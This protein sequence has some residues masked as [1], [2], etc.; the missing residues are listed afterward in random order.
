MNCPT[1]NATSKIDVGCPVCSGSG[2]GQADGA[3][4]WHCK[5]T[6]AFKD[7]ECVDC[8]GTGGVMHDCDTCTKRDGETCRLDGKPCT[9]RD[10]D[11][12]CDHYDEER[13]PDA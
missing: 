9:D 1:C 8:Q 11:I 10:L 13:A 2:E 4:C 3:S 6:G 5:G 12:C 7:Q